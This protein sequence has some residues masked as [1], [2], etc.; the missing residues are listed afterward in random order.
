MISAP[1]E[2]TRSEAVDSMDIGNG[3]K[4]LVG[5]KEI[6]AGFGVRS[7]KTMKKKVRKHGIPILTV[8]RKPTISCAEIIQWR[9]SKRSRKMD[10]WPT[11]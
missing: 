5:W 9:Q 6:T 7:V 8:A 11:P 3:G 10:W 1:K 4:I 2:V